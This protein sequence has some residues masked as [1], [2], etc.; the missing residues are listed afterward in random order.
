[1]KKAK[2]LSK[3]MGITFNDLVLGM[4]SKVFKRH[5]DV[6]KDENKIITVSVPFTFNSIPKDSADY[7]FGNRFAGLTVFL[8]L[9]SDF[10]EACL[11]ANKMMNKV[12]NSMIPSG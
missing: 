3:Q 11:S 7:K 12:K 10:K 6:Q 1:M 2:A 8:P 4:V 5:F 9:I